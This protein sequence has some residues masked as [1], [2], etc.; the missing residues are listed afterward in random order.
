MEFLRNEAD[1]EERISRAQAFSKDEAMTR[2]ITGIELINRTDTTNPGRCFFCDKP[3]HSPQECYHARTL[4]LE[5]RY[6]LATKSK[7]CLAC[8]KKGHFAKDCR[9]TVKCFFCSRKHFMILCK[10]FKAKPQGAQAETETTLLTG[11]S[12]GVYLQT[13]AVKLCG[14]SGEKL[15]RV[16][17]DSGSQ[18][19]YI[20][21]SVANDL[22]FASEGTVELVHCLFGAETRSKRHNTYKVHIKGVSNNMCIVA[23]VLDEYSIC[24]HIPKLNNREAIHEIVEKGIPLHDAPDEISMLLGADVLANIYTGKIVHLKSGLCAVETTVGWTT[25]GRL[26][27]KPGRDGKTVSTLNNTVSLN[28]QTIP[29]TLWEL[30]TLVIWS[31]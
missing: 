31:R 7:V 11:D 2:P 29:K 5:K 27:G 21:Q 24:G 1:S 12:G 3:Y 28:N 26:K 4:T 16:I 30:E 19:S 22:G 14:P 20:R 18:Q 10:E 15:C 25:M 17:L 13:L 8:L 6:E 23:D 9:T